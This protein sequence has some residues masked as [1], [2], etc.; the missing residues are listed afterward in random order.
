[1]SLLF[2][3][4][5]EYRGLWT[6]LIDSL[7]WFSSLLVYF[8]RI[9]LLFD[10]VLVDLFFYVYFSLYFFFMFLFLFLLFLY[11][12]SLYLSMIVSIYLSLLSSGSGSLFSR[13][14]CWPFLSLRAVVFRLCLTV[15]TCAVPCVFSHCSI[16]LFCSFF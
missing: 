2:A 1:V 4:Y 7:C 15:S 6:D 11:F 10:E 16:E 3:F 13:L 12:L 14:L 9:H 8:Y 5:V